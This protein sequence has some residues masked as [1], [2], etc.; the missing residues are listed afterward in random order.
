MS[1]QNACHTLYAWLGIRILCSSTIFEIKLMHEPTDVIEA[2]GTA[3]S[4]VQKYRPDVDGLRAVAVLSVIF[5]HIDSALIPGGYLGVDVF[6]VI[7]GYL[8]TSIIRREQERGCFSLANFYERRV[9]RIMPA[10]LLVL[11][12][13]T[14]VSSALLLPLDLTGYGKS[15]LATLSFV[16]NIYF[17]LDTHYFAAAAELKPLLHMWSLGVEEQFYLVF[18][19]MLML[20]V[21]FRRAVLPI[22]VGLTV[23]SLLTN[24]AALYLGKANPAFYLIPFRAWEL[25]FGAILAIC[26]Q[27][28]QVARQSS[29]AAFTGVILL[30]LALAGINWLDRFSV[31]TPFFAVVGTTLLIW[32]HHGGLTP[33]GR[34]LASRPFVA[35]GLI[36]YSLYLWHWP[37]L[38]LPRYFLV[39]ELTPIEAIGAVLASM[40]MAAFSLR[41]VEKPFR[42]KG[43]PAK[44]AYAV[45]ATAS[46]IVALAGAFVIQTHGIP[47]R[48]D[49]RAAAI[50]TAVGTNYR[51]GATSYIPFGALY[52]CPIAL[53]SG[54]PDYAD[55][56]LF[57]NSHAQMYVPAVELVLEET[58]RQGLLVPANGCL[59]SVDVNI[60]A[61]CDRIMR[62]NLEAIE[63]LD[64]VRTVILAFTWSVNGKSLVDGA[65]NRL[66]G[67]P[68]SLI[69][70]GV[71]RVIERLHAR[72]KE[73][74]VVGPIAIPGYDIASSVSRKLAFGHEIDDPMWTPERSFLEQHHAAL[75]SLQEREDVMLLMPHEIQCHDERCYFIDEGEALFADGDHIAGA[76]AVRFVP[77]FESA[78]STDTAISRN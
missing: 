69:H 71:E 58:G 68:S 67:D 43:M 25:G 56:V 36:S 77:M 73:V 72:Q 45:A 16:A 62:R 75:T 37:M 18:P 13:T 35:V 52:A 57:G 3:D 27:A 31:P 41:Y 12:V 30:S 78:L 6:F 22:I 29:I 23:I 63:A 51:C 70:A 59:P 53:P 21:R 47:G 17:F 5:Y 50:N 42:Q 49:A 39:R 61:D 65:G 46:L 26:L 74:V 48:L 7:S 8:I 76:V 14:V 40:A 2:R 32:A 11:V 1:A 15:L 60:S 28:T 54:D 34:V 64:E 38:V 33:V 9:R 10:L 4:H 19:L 55:V 24:I 20:L 66:D 44:R